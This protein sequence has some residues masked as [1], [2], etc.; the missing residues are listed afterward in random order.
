MITFVQIL[1]CTVSTRLDLHLLTYSS[2]SP[3][4]LLAS[5]LAFD[6]MLL[7]QSQQQAQPEECSAIVFAEDAH[8]L[9]SS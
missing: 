2:D 3:I 4:A 6:K 1:Q 5:R 9:P 7:M 8:I